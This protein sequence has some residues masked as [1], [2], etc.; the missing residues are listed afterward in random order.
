MGKEM[1]A[2]ITFGMEELIPAAVPLPPLIVIPK[3]DCFMLS[4]PTIG[5]FRDPRDIGITSGLPRIIIRDFTGITSKPCQVLCLRTG[6]V[7]SR[8]DAAPVSATYKAPYY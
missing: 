1:E 7:F 6:L 2:T 5:V 4:L 8:K 3:H